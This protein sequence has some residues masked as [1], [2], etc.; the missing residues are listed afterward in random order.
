VTAGLGD[1]VKSPLQNE[2][3]TGVTAIHDALVGRGNGETIVVIPR[4][5]REEKNRVSGL[6]PGF[7][8]DSSG[9]AGH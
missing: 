1:L 3:H 4:A 6:K 2:R 5:D 8:G 7:S 9:V